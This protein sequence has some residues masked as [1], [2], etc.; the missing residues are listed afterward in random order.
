MFCL[1]DNMRFFLYNR[2]TDMRKSFH[3]LSGIVTNVMG[4]DPRNG[5]VYIFMN[6]PRNRIK[7]LHWE[8]G[9]MVLYSKL[10]EAGTFSRPGSCDG[11]SVCESIEWRD[12]V[13]IVEG[14][15]ED[16]NARRKRIENSEKM[17]L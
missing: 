10:L 14:I 3:T 5:D 1:N 8:P 13:M 12:L 15:V 6:R 11:E 9:G 4:H 7:L 2:A 17:R 16:R